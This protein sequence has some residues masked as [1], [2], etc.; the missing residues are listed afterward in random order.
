MCD[1]RELR[2][3][4]KG[5]I[6]ALSEEER[7]IRSERIAARLLIH[8]AFLAA[9]KVFLY[10]SM[11]GEAETSSL[12]KAALEMGK[13]VFLPRIEGEE[14]ALVRYTAGDPLLKNVYGIE[15]PTGE[16]VTESPDLAIIP[17]VA[18]DRDKH[19]LGRGKGFYDRFLA[20]FKGMSIALAF[21]EQEVP[22]V[23][24]QS[25]DRKADVIITDKEII[26]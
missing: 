19:R 1:K 22:A 11:A 21:S 8:P 10:R 18:F 17:L 7:G 15:E 5:R 14:M 23:P 24:T 4:V 13:I 16:G 2:R 25:F 12:L 20:R 3:E 6:S 26:S 9:K